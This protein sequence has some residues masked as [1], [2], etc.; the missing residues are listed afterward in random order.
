MQNKTFHAY[1]RGLIGFIFFIQFTLC[2]CF[3]TYLPPSFSKNHK[4]TEILYPTENSLSSMEQDTPINESDVWDTSDID[5]SYIQPNRKLIALTFDDAPSNG[6]ENLLAIFADFNYQ[7]PDCKATATIFCNGIRFDENTMQTLHAALAMGMELGNHTFSHYD[8]TIL[9]TTQKREE[10]DRTDALLMKVDGKKRHLLRTPYG[11]IDADVK[12]M[13]QAP[14]ID[15]SIDTRDW[16]NVSVQEICDEVLSKKFSG[17]IV[18]MHDGYLHTRYA[19]KQLLFD[20][21]QEGYQAVSVS[22]MAKM[23]E[24]RLQNGK[25]YI[26]ARKQK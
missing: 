19:L 3:N 16:T 26:R 23:H 17:A 8:M 14:I 10:I 13:A 21:K 22:A 18:L 6:L 24:C 5:L 4:K 12:M 25:V 1:S 15:W 20:L 9:N 2:G 7:N 11:K